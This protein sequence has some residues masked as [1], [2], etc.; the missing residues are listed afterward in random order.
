MRD[1]T[2]FVLSSCSFCVELPPTTWPTHSL[3]PTPAL[4]FSTLRCTCH[5]VSIEE[6]DLPEGATELWLL[7]N[8]IVEDADDDDE[9]AV[10]AP[11]GHA[12]VRAVTSTIFG[13]LVL[14][15]RFFLTASYVCVS[16]PLLFTQCM[17]PCC[18]LP[19]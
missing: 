16:F 13:W 3:T 11:P 4:P 6:G 1:T 14:C 9:D 2:C 17:L 12:C 10:S 8:S 7:A 5:K 18:P 15:H 19:R